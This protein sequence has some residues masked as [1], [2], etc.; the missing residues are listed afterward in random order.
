MPPA[1]PALQQTPAEI[2]LTHQLLK[3]MFP[4]GL[5]LDKYIE[6]LCSGMRAAGIVT[7]EQLAQFLAQTGHESGGYTQ[8]TEGLNYAWLALMERWPRHFPDERT[9]RAYH[10]QPERIANRAY[11]MRMGNNDEASGDG[12]RFRGGGLI[13]LTG[14][15]NYDRFAR[16]AGIPLHD[17]P[18]YV[19]LPAGAVHAALWYWRDQRLAEL[20]GDVERVT[21]KINGGMNGYQDRRRLYD[22]ALDIIGSAA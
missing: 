19:R 15:A 8:L 20:H 4:R 22:L 5:W 6:P 7:H 9:A 16:H 11:A 14:R 3:R 18:E 17:A 21:R 10:R 1:Q 13:Q 2:A 12:W